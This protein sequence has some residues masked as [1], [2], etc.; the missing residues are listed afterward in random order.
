M[1]N[2]I[3]P[4]QICLLPYSSIFVA[5]AVG[6]GLPHQGCVDPSVT[7]LLHH[8]YEK[9]YTSEYNFLQYRVF[10]KQDLSSLQNMVWQ[11]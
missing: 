4:S 5:K 8:A 10:G 6:M 3:F 1:S 7:M 9:T 2:S 11:R